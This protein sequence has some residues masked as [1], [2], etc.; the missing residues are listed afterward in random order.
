MAFAIGY[1]LG[2]EKIHK[3][4][5]IQAVLRTSKGVLGTKPP[6]YKILEKKL[7]RTN[8]EELMDKMDKEYA[9]IKD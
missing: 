2:K 1:W 6:K 9:Q 4:E 7:P 3:N 8:D 5:A